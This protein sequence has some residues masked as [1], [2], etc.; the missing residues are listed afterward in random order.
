[1][2]K[3]NSSYMDDQ[4]WSD[5]RDGWPEKEGWEFQQF[6]DAMGPPDYLLVLNA[7]RATCEERY[8]IK[9]GIDEINPEDEE[10]HITGMQGLQT[11]YGR[12]GFWA[13]PRHV[14]FALTRFF[15]SRQTRYL[16]AVQSAFGSINLLVEIV[17]FRLATL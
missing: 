2:A 10:E 5:V 13:M 17:G 14:G 11:T 12:Q 1:M 4:S 3:K 6:L 8:K 15:G 9:E 7:T 16:S